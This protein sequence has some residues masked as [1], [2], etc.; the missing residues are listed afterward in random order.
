MAAKKNEVAKTDA[1]KELALQTGSANLPA[2]MQEDMGKGLENMRAEDMATPRLILMQ[3]LSKELLKNNALSAGDF[4]HSATEEIFSEPLLV[5]PIYY[6]RRYLL[7]NPRDSGGGILARSDDGVNWSPPNAEFDVKLDK[8]DGGHKVKWKTAPTVAKSGL[9]EWGSMNPA[10][11]QSPPAATLMHNF[12]FAFPDDPERMPAV[13][14]FQRSLVTEGRKF[15]TRLKAQRAPMF[16]TVFELSST[17][18]TKGDNSFKGVSLVGKGL[19]TDDELYQR[20]KQLNK[21]FTELGMKIK[22]EEELG[23]EPTGANQ[24]DGAGTSGKY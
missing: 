1:K 9:A 2:F 19:I 23:D 5:T 12:V 4:F 20:F 17:D 15:L 7:W 14:T 22:S 13:F 18:E 24:A 10:D 3:A 8:K 11:P 6:D 16:G 21:T